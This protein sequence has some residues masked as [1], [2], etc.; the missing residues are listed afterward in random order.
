[1]ARVDKLAQKIIR[2]EGG[3]VNDPDD[4]GGATKYG[5]TLKTWKSVGYD[6]DSDGDIDEDDVKLLTHEDAINRVLVPLYWNRWKADAIKNQSVADILVDWVYCSGKW[7]IIWPQRILKVADDGIVGP[8]T[9]DAINSHADP[10]GLFHQ[11]KQARLNFCENICRK[12][13]SQK[14]F[15]QGWKNRIDTFKYER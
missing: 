15:L 11:I 10:L 13:P 5:V 3:F 6:K 4:K 2:L 14:K 1:M 8:R 9:L 12:D 7:G